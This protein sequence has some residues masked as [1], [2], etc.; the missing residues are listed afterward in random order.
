MLVRWPRLPLQ[1]ITIG[2]VLIAISAGPA[3]DLHLMSGLGEKKVLHGS[4]LSEGTRAESFRCLMTLQDYLK[5]NVDPQRDLIFWWDLDESQRPLFASAQ[6]LYVSA[7]LDVTKE[8][9][10]GSGRLY[11]SNTTLVH[12][13]AHPDRLPERLRVLASRGLGVENERRA[14]LSYGGQRFMVE[15]EDLA[16]LGGLH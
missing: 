4:N 16:G 6:S 7:Y 10:S 2:L 3:G 15:L 9:S 14:E 13:T 11:P 1:Y 8:L 12:L 5:S